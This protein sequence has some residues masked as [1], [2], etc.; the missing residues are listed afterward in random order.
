[1]KN[2]SLVLISMIFFI[3][4]CA[5][6]TVTRPINDPGEQTPAY[7]GGGNA[8]PDPVHNDSN[9]WQQE[10]LRRKVKEYPVILAGDHVKKVLVQ[11]EMIFAEVTQ[12][13]SG[14]FTIIDTHQLDKDIKDEVMSTTGSGMLT[15]QDILFR[16][17]SAADICVYLWCEVNPYDGNI[18][19]QPKRFYEARLGCRVVDMFSKQNLAN[20]V[21]SSGRKYYPSGS[22]DDK[23]RRAVETVLPQLASELQTTLENRLG[24][25]IKS[26]FRIRGVIEI[27]EKLQIFKTV[28]K[29]LESENY[30]RIKKVIAESAHF[31]YEISN[32]T[33]NVGGV[34]EL[35]TDT[36][37]AEGL[38]INVRA[39]ERE[40]TKLIQISL[41]E[42]SDDSDF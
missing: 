33:R 2:I 26:S 39:S 11:Q 40:N 15:Y 3:L 31:E 19:G 1:M 29:D 32:P 10:E 41:Q 38:N 5:E 14:T 28:L 12:A 34:A 16:K 23:Q 8:T 17:F 4:S 30:F 37:E 18:G 36:A 27:P 13:L 42:A 24:D 7:M 35:L 9:S 25:I 6:T 22:L 20:I 21:K